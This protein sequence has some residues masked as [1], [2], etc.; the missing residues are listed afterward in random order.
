M[1][2]EIRKRGYEAGFK[3]AKEAKAKGMQNKQIVKTL[4]VDDKRMA[5]TFMEEF[6]VNREKG[7]KFG[8]IYSFGFHDGVIQAVF[9]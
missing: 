8:V 4:E 7:F 5:K 3:A 9:E 2:A 1:I 6:K